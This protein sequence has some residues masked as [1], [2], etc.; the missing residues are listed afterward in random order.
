MTWGAIVA[1]GVSLAGGMMANKTLAGGQNMIKDMTAFNPTNMSG[2][3]MGSWATSHGTNYFTPSNQF[4]GLAS[5]LGTAG[6]GLLGGGLYNDPQLQQA[7]AGM[8]LPGHYQDAQQGLMQQAFSNYNAPMFQ[9][10]MGNMSQL[11]NQAAG[12]AGMGPQ[13]TSGGMQQGL[14]QGGAQNL[15][16][17]G[18]TSG[19]VQQQLDASRALAQPGED[20]LFNKVQDRLFAQGRMGTTGGSQEFGEAINQIGMAD[21]QRIMNAQQLGM[22]NQQQ[23]GQLGLGQMQAGTGLM[24]QNWQNWMGAG[25]NAQ[26]FAGQLGQMEGQGFNQNLQALQQN[27]TAGQNRLQNAMGLFGMGRQTLEG[28]AGLGGTLANAYTGLMGLPMQGTLGLLNAEANRIGA[29]GMHAQALGQGAQAQGGL[30]G[31]LMGGLGSALGGL[32]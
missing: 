12:I 1:G 32:F 6:A 2:S 8:N 4:S 30:L 28:Q 7:L 24:G 10:G 16:Q 5:G 3:P 19:L 14:F 23:L 27:Q 18:N 22:Q 26:G 20:R 21:Q 9:Q 29:T 11:G 13:D 15:M 31:G 17:A 25:Q